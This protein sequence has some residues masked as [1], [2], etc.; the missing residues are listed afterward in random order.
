MASNLFLPCY[1]TTANMFNK[2]FANNFSPS[3]SYT[4]NAPSLNQNDQMF[5]ASFIDTHSALATSNSSSAGPDGISGRVLRNLAHV[6]ALPVSI[7]FQQSLAPGI[8]PS[9]WKVATVI[10]TYKGKGARYSASTYRPIRFCSTIVR[11]L[12]RIV[13]EQLLSAIV[14][15][16]PLSNLQHGFFNGRSTITNLLCAEIII[17]DAINSKEP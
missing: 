5:N 6:L 8:F 16:T 10:P 11:A 14:K 15:T 13:R 4:L 17:A 9:A 1:V 7:I 3:V 12:E 2:E